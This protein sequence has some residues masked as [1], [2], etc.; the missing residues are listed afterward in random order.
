MT[1]EEHF[2]LTKPPFH[3]LAPEAAMSSGAKTIGPPCVQQAI[4]DLCVIS[5][6]VILK[7]DRLN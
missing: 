2:G 3:R 1:L 5:V 4:V 7:A 6:S